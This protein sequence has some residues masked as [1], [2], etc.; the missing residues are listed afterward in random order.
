MEDRQWPDR[1]SFKNHRGFYTM[2][3]SKTSG[4]TKVKKLSAA[5]KAAPKKSAPKKAAP[6]KSA[7]KKS[8]PK[9]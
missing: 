4:T 1:G 2:A 9:K 6:K 7:P 8:A 5:K 3:M